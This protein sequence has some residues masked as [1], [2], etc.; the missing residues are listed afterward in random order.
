MR[1]T[2]LPTISQP[3]VPSKSLL[4][5]NNKSKLP[6]HQLLLLNKKLPL[7]NPLKTSSS[8]LVLPV[9][10]NPLSELNKKLSSS[11]ALPLESTELESNSVAST[12][13]METNL[14]SVNKDK[15]KVK[16]K[17]SNNKLRFS[18]PKLSSNNNRVNPKLLFNRNKVKNKFP[19]NSN[20]LLLLLTLNLNKS[21]FL[22][23]SNTSSSNKLL[24]STNTTN[25]S[26]IRLLNNNKITLVSLN[27]LPTLTTSNNNLP[28][29]LVTLLLLLLTVTS[30]NKVNN[31]LNK[32]PRINLLQ[33]PL[34][35][36][37]PNTSNPRPFPPL[38]TN[39]LPHLTLLLP[40]PSNNNKLPLLNLLTPRSTRSLNSNNSR[41]LLSAR[42]PTIT[43]V[44]TV[45][46]A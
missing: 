16:A 15:V 8:V 21:K 46:I 18:N 31:N 27:L 29:S 1:L 6:S 19:F 3:L 28:P 24:S 30:S 22:N 23:N 20:K 9:S 44:S 11:P 33:P 40:S 43:R 14:R 13:S 12:C 36:L 38:T 10:L 2:F 7:N 5:N 4:L 45:K 34:L 25:T 39:N 35:P 37:T 41:K 32:E 42:L 26:S 17:V